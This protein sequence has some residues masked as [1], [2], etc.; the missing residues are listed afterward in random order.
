LVISNG[1]QYDVQNADVAIEIEGLKAANKLNHQELLG[2]LRKFPKLESS[3]LVFRNTGDGRF[4]DMSLNWGFEGKGISQG[5]ALGDLD[6][7]G[8]LDLV[9]NNL[10]TEAGLYRNESAA[11]RISVRLSGALGNTGGAGARIRVI[12]GAVPQS[13]EM[14][15]GGRY[16]SGDDMLR[17]FAAL[18]GVSGVEVT[19]RNG[20]KRLI[21]DVKANHSY[22][23]EETAH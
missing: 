1:N 23:I 8:D 10:F 17:V 11:P 16:L 22:V 20:K 4:K 2:L 21:E 19:W 14:L 13:Q 12:G 9:I 18:P 6:N 3:K 15:S 5:M 7:D